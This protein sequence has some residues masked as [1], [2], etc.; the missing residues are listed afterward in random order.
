VELVVEAYMMRMRS[1]TVL[2]LLTLVLAACGSRISVDESPPPSTTPDPTRTPAD[3]AANESGAYPG[4]GTSSSVR[5]RQEVGGTIN[6]RIPFDGIRPIYDPTFSA[7][8]DAVTLA[9]TDLV[10]GVSLNGDSRAYPVR[11]LRSR[12]MVNDIVGGIPILATW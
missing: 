9:P 10:I 8:A 1:L 2:T 6:T 11:T 12:E 7:G 3:A 5:H 4:I